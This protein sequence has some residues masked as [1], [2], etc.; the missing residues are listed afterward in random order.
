MIAQAADACA[1]VLN[2]LRASGRLRRTMVAPAADERTVEAALLDS[3]EQ[4][5][6]GGTDSA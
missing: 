6:R 3:I 4:L 1:I 5:R 2:A